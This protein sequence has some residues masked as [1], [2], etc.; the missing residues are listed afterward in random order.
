MGAMTKKAVRKAPRRRKRREQQPNVLDEDE[1]TKRQVHHA[2]A[3]ETLH[4]YTLSNDD[5]R[6]QA[7]HVFS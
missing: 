7:V 5:R 2:S 6:I 4:D 3:C 1:N